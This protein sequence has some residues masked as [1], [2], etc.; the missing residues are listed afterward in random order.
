M[1]ASCFSPSKYFSKILYLAP[2][3]KP[4][5][6]KQKRRI[7]LG[8]TVTGAPSSSITCC[9]VGGESTGESADSII[10]SDWRSFRAKLVASE[11]VL[12]HTSLTTPLSAELVN[13][14][15]PPPKLSNKWAHSLHEPE[16]GCLLVA[17]DKLD[18]VHIFERTVI[19][20]LS[21][22]PLSAMGVI[23]NRPSL[24]SIKET[25]SVILDAASTFS[26]RPLF[27]GGPLEDGIFLVAPEENDG[28]IGKSGVFEEVMKGL[29]YG[30]KESVGC[31]S[32]MV[33]RDMVGIQEFRFFD[34]YCGWATEKLREEVRAGFWRVVAC[35]PSVIGPASTEQGGLWE[36]VLGL[37]GERKVW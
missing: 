19:L 34:G 22:G 9:S 24:M 27:F 37:V 8:L 29:Y 21:M 28:D 20:L 7:G 26:S 10:Q 11:H 6:S 25:R 23:L 14:T 15:L 2:S 3:L 18:G 17:T 5:L 33:K 13:Q 12:N 31:A 30:T 36:E 1:E 35:S 16:K 4:K 32:E